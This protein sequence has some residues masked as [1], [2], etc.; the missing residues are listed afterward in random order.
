M[1][2]CRFDGD[3]LGVV[4][5]GEVADVSEVLERV[6]P[7]RWP[8]LAG[9]PLI[10]RLDELRVAIGGLLGRAPRRPLSEVRLDSPIPRPG[11]VIAAPVNYLAHL[12]EVRRDPEIHRSRRIAEIHEAGLFLKAPSSVVGPAEGPRIPFP[13]RRTDHEI[14]L[15]VVIGRRARNLPAGEALGCVA[16]Y[17][18][19]L[20]M[21][22]RGPQERSLRKSFDG[23]TVLGPWLVTAE[24]IPEPQELELELLCDGALRQ[25]A[26]TADMVLGVADLLAFASRWYTLEPGDVLLTGTPEGVG[27]VHPGSRLAAR[28]ARIGTLETVVRGP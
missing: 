21:T 12:E 14:E 19:G 1:R 13:D 24:E 18:V 27:P 6:P 3:R 25:K 26:S 5:D 22:V 9:D 15:A 11:K 16:S 8:D 2:L 23:A 17:T 20:D 4:L 10:A 28:I 7:K